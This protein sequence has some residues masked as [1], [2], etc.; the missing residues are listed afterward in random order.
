MEQEPVQIQ[1]QLQSKLTNEIVELF[2]LLKEGYYIW[3]RNEKINSNI[4][5]SCI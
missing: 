3:K 2:N 5:Y 1:T 4:I